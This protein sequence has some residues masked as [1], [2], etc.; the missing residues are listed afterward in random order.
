MYRT[1]KHRCVDGNI[2]FFLHMLPPSTVGAWLE[3]VV[4]LPCRSAWNQSVSIIFPFIPTGGND[5]FFPLKKPFVSWFKLREWCVHSSRLFP[6]H[7]LQSYTALAFTHV[8]RPEVASG[9]RF[10]FMHSRTDAAMPYLSP[11][12]DSSLNLSRPT[13]EPYSLLFLFATANNQFLPLQDEGDGY[14]ISIPSCS[15][16]PL[17]S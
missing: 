7:M 16:S 4:E 9:G 17:L 14:P 1:Q 12:P 2:A 3:L 5:V 15:L 13:R 10:P 11:P 8:T 6:F